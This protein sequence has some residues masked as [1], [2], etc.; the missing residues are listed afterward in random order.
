MLKLIYA[1]IVSEMKNQMDITMIGKI[2]QNFAQ[3]QP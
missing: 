3:N 2:Y 1:T